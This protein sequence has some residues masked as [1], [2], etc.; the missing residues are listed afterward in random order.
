MRNIFSLI[1][2]KDKVDILEM[3]G[4]YIVWLWRPLA[5]G[6]VVALIIVLKN[7]KQKN[8]IK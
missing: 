8:K 5:L 4:L 3:L 1:S 7:E 2:N 6:Y